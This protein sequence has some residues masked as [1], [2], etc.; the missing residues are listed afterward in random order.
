MTCKEKLKSEYPKL[1]ENVIDTLI[2]ETCTDEYGYLSAPEWCN[3]DIKC[4]EC[5]DR[6]IPYDDILKTFGDACVIT[7]T[8][9]E[10]AMKD[11]EEDVDEVI[12]GLFVG[13]ERLEHPDTDIY[14]GETVQLSRD[15]VTKLLETVDKAMNKIDTPKI[16]C[17][18]GKA[19]NGKDT[20]AGILK[21]ILEKCG[22]RVLITHYGDLV[23]Y[24]CKTFFDWNGEK[25]EAGRGLLQF[26][27]TDRIRA[28]RPNY[29][30]DFVVSIVQMFPD[31][32]DYV[33]IPDSRFPNEID[34]FKEAGFNVTHAR[35]I[36]APFVSPL[37]PEQQIHISE[38][39]LD[40]VRADVY[41]PN[42]G[43]LEDLEREIDGKLVS[44][45]LKKGEK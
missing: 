22:Y 5:W 45:L 3:P 32:W 40:G 43:S 36:R 19:Q 20:S 15:S 35:V 27:G 1:S 26:V 14:H 2:N 13:D 8:M 17:V 28:Q 31:Q 24:V 44:R 11:M 38:T 18:S 29:W 16:I 39:A 30:V 37:T 9:V 6:E 23:K 12:N 10:K 7:N 33:I 41:I 21:D 34:C 4:S 42:F 25:D